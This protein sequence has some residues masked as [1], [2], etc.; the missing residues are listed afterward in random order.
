MSL[1][2]SSRVRTPGLVLEHDIEEGG[3]L[4]ALGVGALVYNDSIVLYIHGAQ[5]RSCFAGAAHDHLPLAASTVSQQLK[6]LEEAGLVKG[7]IDGPRRSY[8][9]NRAALTRAH[10]LLGALAQLERP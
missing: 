3:I 5:Q 2:G 4:A 10:A 1:G 6:Q 7:E 8:C 9:V